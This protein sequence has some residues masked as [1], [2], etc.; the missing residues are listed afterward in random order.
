MTGIPWQWR[1]DTKAKN[2]AFTGAEGE[3]TI[4]KET[5]ALRL[6][7]GLTVGGFPIRSYDQELEN[8]QDV[9]DAIQDEVSERPPE[10]YLINGDFVVA[11]RGTSFTI[12]ASGSAYILDRWLV[13]NDTDQ[14]VT[15]DQSEVTL[16]QTDIPGNPRYKVQLT[17]A[18]AP[19]SGTIRVEQR[20]EGVQK[21]AGKTATARGYFYGPTGAETLAAEVV[22]NFGT[23]G[24]PSS[25][26][27]AGATSLDVATIYNSSS[28]ARS[29]V[30]N[31]PSISGMTYGSNGDD[32]LA[33]AWELSPRQAGIYEIAHM[34]LVEGD[35]SSE[36][37]TFEPRSDGI[38][39]LLCQRYYWQGDADDQGLSYLYA[40]A[41]SGMQGP[42]A[43]FQTEMR[44][45]PTASILTAPTY[46][47]CSSGSLVSSKRGLAHRLTV[48][49][50]GT[51]RALQG[52][53]EADA[54][55]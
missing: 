11:Q 45:E 51:Y 6:H 7:D 9:V 49:S 5:P 29:A 42:V 24:S 14:S 55:L 54:E 25:E 50:A 28:M 53:Y 48:T 33:L 43:S 37:D 2:D 35:A 38:E 36:T 4:D 27:T 16:G 52:I 32:Y 15:V 19:T 39:I 46:S 20:V 30:F 26:V 22:Q 31:V 41:S 1:R 17:F 3:V 12:A 18:T 23:G 10:N 13:T 44:T 40:S 21:L 8:I 34:S 47:S